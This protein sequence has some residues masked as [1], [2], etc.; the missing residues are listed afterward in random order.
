M[1]TKKL[2]FLELENRDKPTQKAVLLKFN[3]GMGQAKVTLSLCHFLQKNRRIANF[4]FWL[5]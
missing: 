3:S 1:W 5:Q 4:I 2:S